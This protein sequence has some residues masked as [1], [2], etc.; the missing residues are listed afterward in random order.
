MCLMNLLC[1]QICGECGKGFYRKDHLRK[2]AKSHLAKRVK[3]EMNAQAAAAAVCTT[4][5]DS[6]NSEN[7]TSSLDLA[8]HHQQ[9]QPIQTPPQHQLTQ[10][11]MLTEGQTICLPAG[12][13]IHVRQ[14]IFFKTSSFI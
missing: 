11:P 8:I 12:V 1:L 2:H 6:Q 3:E 10:H 5:M 7:T 9:Q 13:T 4:T 14:L